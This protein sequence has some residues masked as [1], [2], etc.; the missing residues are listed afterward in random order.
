M[1]RSEAPAL[2]PE[3]QR[4][5]FREFCE[6]EI[7]AGGPDPHMR[8]VAEMSRGEEWVERVWR[9]GVYAGVY[10]VPSAEVI[11]TAWPFERA[12]SAAPGAVEEWLRA[13]W[14]AIVTRRERRCVRRPEQLATY[15]LAYAAWVEG[16]H[17]GW[18]RYAEYESVWQDLDRVYTAGRYFKIKLLEYLRRATGL[19]HGL[20]DL[21]PAGGENPRQ[22]LALL[23][24]PSTA[25]LLLGDDESPIAHKLMNAAFFETQRDFEAEGLRLDSFHYQTL[26]CDYKQSYVGKR[27]YPGRSLDSELDYHRKIAAAVPPEHKTQMFAARAALFPATGLGEVQGWPG[28]RA[29][30]GTV[31]RDFHYTWSDARFDFNATLM[32]SHPAPRAQ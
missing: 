3:T 13:N 16:L 19:P 24:S 31:L 26:L 23:T 29:V 7:A 22:G 2:P 30:L 20:P 6:N 14:K 9:G 1:A 11:W 21:R 32:F 17:G 8:T 12:L 27:Q 25:L 10:N 15:L 18:G 28:V 5:Y 4:R